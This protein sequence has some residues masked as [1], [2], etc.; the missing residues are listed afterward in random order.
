MKDV[1]PIN[2]KFNDFLLTYCKDITII[3]NHTCVYK[4]I[5]HFKN[6]VPTQFSNLSSSLLF[7]NDKDSILNIYKKD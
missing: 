5:Y 3:N 2:I 7:F 6:Q 1:D 4:I